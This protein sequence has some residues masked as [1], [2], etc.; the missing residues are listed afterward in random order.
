MVYS[1]CLLFT[2]IFFCTISFINHHH[3]PPQLYHVPIID[4][5]AEAERDMIL[6]E[7][8]LGGGQGLKFRP[9]GFLE[10]VLCCL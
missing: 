2:K 3:P 6:S 5:E 9:V 7:G 10:S 8:H 1:P 4:G